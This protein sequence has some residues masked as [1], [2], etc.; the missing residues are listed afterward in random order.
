MGKL[1]KLLGQRVKPLPLELP[2][3]LLSQLLL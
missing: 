3:T 1:V 2:L